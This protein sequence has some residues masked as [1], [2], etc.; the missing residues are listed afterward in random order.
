MPAPLDRSQESS[1]QQITTTEINNVHINIKNGG[2]SDNQNEK[3]KDKDNEIEVN[4]SNNIDDKVAMNEK[5]K[6]DTKKK[7]S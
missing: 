4:S 7:K 3:E 1:K 5:E 2:S 6:I